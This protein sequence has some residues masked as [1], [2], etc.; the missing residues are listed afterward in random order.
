M[1]KGK[2][3]FYC[4]MLHV[5]RQAFYEYLQRKDRPWKYQKLADAMQDILK[6]DECND[7]YGRSGMRDALLQKKPK[8]VDIPS[9]RTVYRVMEEIGRQSSSR[10]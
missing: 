5:S 4:R 8:N 2:P 6:E 3:T 10:A 9:E 1:I 7:T